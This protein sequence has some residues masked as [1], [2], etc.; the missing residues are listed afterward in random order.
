MDKLK[1]YEQ[2]LA[3]EPEIHKDDEINCTLKAQFPGYINKYSDQT[4]RLSCFREIYQKEKKKKLK[5][6]KF[7]LKKTHQFETESLCGI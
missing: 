7:S 4:Q 5:K 1:T 6:P 3:I 2:N